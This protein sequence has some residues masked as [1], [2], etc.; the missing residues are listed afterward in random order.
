M[1][2][3][4]TRKGFERKRRKWKQLKKSV[5]RRE[6]EPGWVRG[7]EQMLKN[8]EKREEM[9]MRIEKEKNGWKKEEKRRKK[10]RMRRR[11]WKQEA[12]QMMRSEKMQKKHKQ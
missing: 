2:T 11:M 8:G 6:R 5:D 4:K 12:A 10:E 7:L 1:K 9:R 3:R